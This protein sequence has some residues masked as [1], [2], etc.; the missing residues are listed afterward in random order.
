MTRFLLALSIGPVQEFIAAA[1]K[2]ADLYAGSQVLLEVVRAAVTALPAE[3][4]IF[5]ASA[6][7]DGA[8]K[9]LVVVEGDAAG[10]AQR[11]ELAAQAKLLELWAGYIRDIRG[12]IDEARA[13]M[14]LEHFLEVYAAWVPL[15]DDPQQYAQARRRVEALLSGRKALRDFT[16][17]DQG[18]AGVPKSPLD[19]A[20]A[21]VL[22]GG[23]VPRTLQEQYHFKPSE[24]LDAVSLLKRMFG[25][26]LRG[27][28]S[29]QD[30]AHAGAT[31]EARG[32]SPFQPRREE[33]EETGNVPAYP[34]FALLLADGD[35][36]GALLNEPQNNSR[37][38]HRNFSENLDLFARRARDIVG[39]HGGFSV[40]TG[41]DDVL[42]LLPVTQALACGQALARAFGEQVTGATLSAGVAVVHYREP[43][44]ASL[45]YARAAE[46][47]AK[48]VE[49]KN[50]VCVALH[51]RGGTPL[52]VARKWSEAQQIQDWQET[53]L[54]RGLPYELRE[55][56]REWPQD[57][58]PQVLSAEAQRRA[59]RKSDA[60]GQKLADSVIAG[61]TFQSGQDL[62]EFADMLVLARFLSGKGDR[63]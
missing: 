56:A 29:T 47:K 41:G 23:R 48:A 44:S 30:L 20:F 43:L 38:G 52:L 13:T 21:S 50:A 34:Y 63:A 61:M 45:G 58:S 28:P 25:R 1:R 16:A 17:F 31:E 15:T 55:L 10:H 36:M 11:A 8:N 51:T 7:S 2:T 26:R 18:D 49:G 42:A 53:T 24:G 54:P 27:V 62:Q 3:G 6:E 57:F 35:S 60:E 22:K 5:P 33:A 9:I 19:P 14:Q 40:Y 39:Q 46:K 12:D 37:H 4:L 32:R 59:K